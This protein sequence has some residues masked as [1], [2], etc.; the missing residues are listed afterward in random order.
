[1]V[2]IS[3]PSGGNLVLLTLDDSSGCCID[4]KLSLCSPST[5]TGTPTT[6]VANVDY[7]TAV[8]A[9]PDLRVDGVKVDVGTVLKVKCTL[10]VFRGTKQL[11]LK[12]C[13]VIRDTT[14]EIMAWEAMA[15]FKRDVLSRPWE[16][17]EAEQ[18]A[19]DE[20]EKEEEEK[21]RREQRA[22][23]KKEESREKKKKAKEEQREKRRLAAEEKFNRGA[24][25]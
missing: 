6:A 15:A 8:G 13:S 14:E 21:K 23:R 12:R 10:G 25:V 7:T 24:L 17:S 11:E 3:E 2:A 4:V 16:L 20:R 9:D 5:T 18:K 1:M 19:W 22:L